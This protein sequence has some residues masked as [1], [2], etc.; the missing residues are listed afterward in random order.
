MSRKGGNPLKNIKLTEE[1]PHAEVI[2]DIAAGVTVRATFNLSSHV[3]RLSRGTIGIWD[4]GTGRFKQIIKKSTHKFSETMTKDLIIPAP[5][6]NESQQDI[7]ERT[8]RQAAN[9]LFNKYRSQILGELRENKSLAKHSLA[10]VL[11]VYGAD[12]ISDRSNSAEMRKTYLRQLENLANGIGEKPLKDITKKDLT[13]FCKGHKGEN[14][15]EY[16]SNFQSFLQDTAFRIG[17]EQPCRDALEAFF[18]DVNK[19]QKANQKNS[20]PRA[21]V[22]PQEFEAKLDQGCWDNLGDPS[23]GCTIV[24]KEGGLDPSDVCK[25]RIKDVF[26]GETLEEVYILLRKDNIATYTNDYS[27]PL[28]PFGGSY[29]AEYL[30]M[31]ENTRPPERVDGEKFLFASDEKGDVPL[32][33][34]E[35]AEFLRVQ[36]SRYLF[37]YAG[38]VALKN[39]KTIS[40]GAKLLKDTRQKH[41]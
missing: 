27:F 5:A 21:D 15:P 16:I 19:A 36:L 11:E 20:P 17:L 6:A 7:I 39:G 34:S 28:S 22:L 4:S 33:A 31:L 32:C 1:T 2:F 29:I 14:G 30:A 26:R 41:L 35:I 12:Y 8:T 23:W 37:G 9:K 40:M 13:N 24:V 18:R 25:L 10:Q 3:G 38:H